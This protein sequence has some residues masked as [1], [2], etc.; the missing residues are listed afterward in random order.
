MYARIAAAIAWKMHSDDFSGG[1]ELGQ[2][3]DLIRYRMGMPH[4]SNQ[5]YRP[6]IAYASHAEQAR[7][8]E[9]A[10][11]VLSAWEQAGSPR[12]KAHI[13]HAHKLIFA[14]LRRAEKR[15]EAREVLREPSH[16]TRLR[17]SMDN[18]F[19]QLERNPIAHL[20]T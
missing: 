5:P 6:A 8:Q 18:L 20:R 14:S 4:P 13:E 1:R 3:L 10:E 16:A 2:Y 7:V 9:V 12:L 17:T 15:E 19:N 11:G